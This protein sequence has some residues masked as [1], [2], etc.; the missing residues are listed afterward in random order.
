VG[1]RD[2]QLDAAQ[3]PPGEL[4]QELGPERFGLRRADIHAEHL[5]A[6]ISVDRNRDD[7]RH[8]H[9]TAALPHFDVSRIDP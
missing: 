4:A 1:I 7:H 5:A 8:R 9:D 6:A 2:H 3:A